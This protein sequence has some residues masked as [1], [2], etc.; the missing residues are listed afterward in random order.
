[1]GESGSGK[2]VTLRAILGLVPNPG[3]VEAGHVLLDGQEL[4]GA[5]ARTLQGSVVA[6]SA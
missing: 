3:R 6:I 5:P 2:S 4:V 1:M